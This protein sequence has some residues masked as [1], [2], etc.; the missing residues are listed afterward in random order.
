MYELKII[1]T[2]YGRYAEMIV[3]Q[4]DP[5]TAHETVLVYQY[6]LHYWD[7]DD[8]HLEVDKSKAS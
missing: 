1:C 5:F 2:K 3:K 8:L 6:A 4:N 7:C